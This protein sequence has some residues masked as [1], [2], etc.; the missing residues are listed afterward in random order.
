[1]PELRQ[2][3]S[4]KTTGVLKKVLLLLG[5]AISLVYCNTPQPATTSPGNTDTAT[6][7]NRNRNASNNTDTTRRDS[8][9]RDSLRQQ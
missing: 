2:A 7:M 1:M 9:R 6:S 3:Q 4:L 5:L 8:T